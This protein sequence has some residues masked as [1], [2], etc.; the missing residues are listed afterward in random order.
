MVILHFD[1]QVDG[2]VHCGQQNVGVKP[3]LQI[4]SPLWILYN[5]RRPTDAIPWFG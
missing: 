4:G 5:S 3:P 1:F 2:T